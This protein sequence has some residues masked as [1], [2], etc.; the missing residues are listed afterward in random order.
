MGYL[1]S[2]RGARL[3][4]GLMNGD[5]KSNAPD[6]AKSPVSVDDYQP[7]FSVRWAQSENSGSGAWVIWLPDSSKLVMVEGSYVTPTGITAANVYPSGFYTIDNAAQ[8]ST[9]IWLVVHIPDEGQSSTPSAEFDTSPGTATTGESVANI[10]IAQM[11]TNSTS[12]WVRTKQF[13]D[14]AIVIGKGGGSVTPDDVSTE[15][16]PDPPAGQQPTGD[17]GKLQVKGWDTGTPAAQTTLAAELAASQSDKLLIVRNADGTLAYMSPGHFAGGSL[18][19]GSVNVVA[20]WNYGYYD[21]GTGSDYRIRVATAPLS[22][23][24]Q[25]GALELGQASYTYINTV[26]LSQEWT[27]N[28]SS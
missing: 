27:N 8:S 3:L 14:S 21:D 20:G 4:R 15:F 13:V 25:T 7:P 26:P 9:A 10:L 17:E 28:S 12:G 5:Q 18:P 23:N 19:T 11:V 1:L 22:V 6:F 16:I 24:Q 2:E